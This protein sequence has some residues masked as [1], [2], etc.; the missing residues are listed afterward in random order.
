MKKN[1]RIRFI[2]HSGII[3]AVYVVLTCITNLFG[4]ASGAVQ[5]R[6]SEAMCVLPA[7]VPGAVPG[8]FIGCLLS[9]ILNGCHVLD[10]VFG[11]LA[12]LAGAFGTYLLSKSRMHYL[13]YPV[14][15]IVS[16]TVIIPFV[17]KYAYGLKEGILYFFFTV[18]LGELV[19][20]GILGTFLYCY[21]RKNAKRIF[22]L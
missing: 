8:L 19:S 5:C 14:P 9:N 16:N 17:L 7:F 4:L 15:A 1:N 12:T 20:C 11:S 13:T 18:G 21:L 10:V 22:K 6:L 2:C 3:A